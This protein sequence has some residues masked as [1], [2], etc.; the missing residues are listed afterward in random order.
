VAKPTV[1][2]DAWR[3]NEEIKRKARGDLKREKMQERM[4]NTRNRLANASAPM[5]AALG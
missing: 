4:M 3:K 1:F 5:V 2:E